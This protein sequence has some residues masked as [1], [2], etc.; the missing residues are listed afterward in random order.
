MRKA[1]E[2]M[3]DDVSNLRVKKN[4][5]RRLVNKGIVTVSVALGYRRKNA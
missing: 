5:L 2:T 3:L 4:P 1:V